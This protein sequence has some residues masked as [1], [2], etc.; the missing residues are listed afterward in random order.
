MK[1]DLIGLKLDV[2]FDEAKEVKYFKE[3]ANSK[4][5]IM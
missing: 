4:G 2:L 3:I 1:K 5:L